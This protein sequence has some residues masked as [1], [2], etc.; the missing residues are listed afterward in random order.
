[1]MAVKEIQRMICS[2]HDMFS[3]GM[4]VLFHNHMFI[5][6]DSEGMVSS[7]HNM[8]TVHDSE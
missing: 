7:L 4:V 3:E 1:M 6:N 2:F 8:F 5:M